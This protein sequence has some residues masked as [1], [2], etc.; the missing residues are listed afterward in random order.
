MYG[1]ALLAAASPPD[2]SWYGN[3]RHG[4]GFVNVKDFGAMGDGVADDTQ[5]IQEAIDSNRLQERLP[6]PPTQRPFAPPRRAVVYLP[7]GT[8]AVSDTISLWFFTHL[9]VSM[10]TPEYTISRFEPKLCTLC[11]LGL[12]VCYI[13]RGNA[14]RFF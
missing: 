7:P 11:I 8:Y 12:T 13:L 9:R 4:E 5:A 6:P 10:C 3:T 2:T 1:I 14:N